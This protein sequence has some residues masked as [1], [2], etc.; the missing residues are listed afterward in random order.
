M[1]KDLFEAVT[2]RW[3]QWCEDRQPQKFDLGDR[4][5]KA[6]WV[7]EN[8][9]LVSYPV[10]PEPRRHV[11]QTVDDLIGA[12][13]RWGA[14]AG[15][16]SALWLSEERVLAVL[17]DEDDHRLD[18]VELPL[19]KTPLFAFCNDLA[20]RGGLKQG[21]LVRALRR[22]LRIAT[23]ATP[24]LSEVRNVRFTGAT[25]ASG[26]VQHGAESLG[27]SIENKLTGADRLPDKL[28]VPVQVFDDPLFD[29]L[30]PFELTLDLEVDVSNQKFHLSPLPGD[31]DAALHAALATIAEK[32]EQEFPAAV[33]HGTP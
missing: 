3:K 26:V 6:V 4:N 17:D 23:G 12:V 29:E 20:K 15:R 13:R 28:I 31:L 7:R 2:A 14:D 10:A 32:L 24:L 16:S 21:D 30:E 25:E 11:V 9:K 1:L 5:L 19:R 22:E 27:R 8:G 18:S 33:F